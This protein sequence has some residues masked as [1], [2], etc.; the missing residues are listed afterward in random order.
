MECL[1]PQNEMGYINP[2]TVCII[3]RI[4]RS[5][6]WHHRWYNPV[7]TRVLL[8]ASHLLRC[9]MRDLKCQHGFPSF[10]D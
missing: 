1:L 4:H 5:R 8:K 10:G 2:Y 7:Q 6:Q 9:I 3:G